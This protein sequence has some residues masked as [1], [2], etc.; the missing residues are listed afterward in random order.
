MFNVMQSNSIIYNVYYT[1]V[2]INLIGYNFL[3]ELFFYNKIYNN[4]INYDNIHNN[5][6]RV[7]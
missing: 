2:L 5:F 4:F 6:I 3:V 1:Q 7:I